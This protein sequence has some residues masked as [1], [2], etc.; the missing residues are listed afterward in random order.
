MNRMQQR[1]RQLD[2]LGKRITGVV[3]S[4]F[5]LVIIGVILWHQV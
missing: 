5:L 4:V 1:G 2:Q 3:W